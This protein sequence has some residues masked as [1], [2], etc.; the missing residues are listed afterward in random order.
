MVLSCTATA[1]STALLSSERQP[2]NLELS[3]LYAAISVE[4]DVGVPPP[5]TLA[6]SAVARW[7]ICRAS[8]SWVPSTVWKRSPASFRWGPYWEDH[9]VSLAKDSSG[10]L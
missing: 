9:S 3:P 5:P 10:S 4:V 1:A 2:E 8:R 7:A 6:A